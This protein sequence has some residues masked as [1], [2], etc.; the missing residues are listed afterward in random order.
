MTSPQNVNNINKYDHF[1]IFAQDELIHWLN[2]SKFNH[3]KFIK[4]TKCVIILKL[5]TDYELHFNY[6]KN[7]FSVELFGNVTPLDIDL[8][9]MIN[10]IIFN[11][12]MNLSNTL[13]FIV[14]TLLGI[15][16]IKYEFIDDTCYSMRINRVPIMKDMLNMINMVNTVNMINMVKFDELFGDVEDVEIDNNSD[17]S[18]NSNDSNDIK[19]IILETETNNVFNMSNKI[20]IDLDDYVNDEL[21]DFEQINK[22]DT[23]LDNLNNQKKIVDNINILNTLNTLNTDDVFKIYDNTQLKIIPNH[24]NHDN[25]DNNINKAKPIT[26]NV[27]NNINLIK[28]TDD[29]ILDLEAYNYVQTKI[30]DNET[31]RRKQLYY[32]FYVSIISGMRMIYSNL[33]E[34]EI[35]KI[36]KKLHLRYKKIRGQTIPKC[37]EELTKYINSE[38][39]KMLNHDID[40]FDESDKLDNMILLTD[41]K[42]YPKELNK[43]IIDEIPFLMNKYINIII[44]N[45][46]HSDNKDIINLTIKPTFFD[47]HS[48]I[49]KKLLNDNQIIKIKITKCVDNLRLIIIYPRIL[50][51][52]FNN[53]IHLDLK[54]IILTIKKKFEDED[55][56]N[57]MIFEYRKLLKLEI[58]I[59]EF[60]YLTGL[61]SEKNNKNKNNV[62]STNNGIGYSNNNSTNWNLNKF[63]SDKNDMLNKMIKCILD[64]NTTII[65]MID[66]KQQKIIFKILNENKML[67]DYVKSFFK[68]NKLMD[69]FKSAKLF[70]NLF[71]FVHLININFFNDTIKE[72]ITSL[73]NLI[74]PCKSYIKTVTSNT[75]TTTNTTTEYAI[76][77]QIISFCEFYEI[78]KENEGK[79]IED[80]INIDDISKLY[81]QE[82]IQYQFQT[83][84]DQNIKKIIHNANNSTIHNIAQENITLMNSMPLDIKSAIFYLCYE[85]DIY[86]NQFL[87]TGPEDTPYSSGCFLFSLTYP[88]NYPNSPPIVYFET[89]GSGMVQFNPNLFS[90]GNICLSLLKNHADREGEQWLPG[91]SSILQVMISLQSLVMVP[92]PFFNEISNEYI[93]NT[94]KG[95]IA[96]KEYNQSIQYY[97]LKYA[98]NDMIMNPPKHFET[99]IKKHFFIKKDI[100]MSIYKKYLN[101]FPD[102]LSYGIKKSQFESEYDIMIE[103]LNE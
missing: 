83:V 37:I 61:T 81:I 48:S 41:T 66:N 39:Y 82:L 78:Q 74:E 25:Y 47:S 30:L 89:T 92:K 100:I 45:F 6:S 77:N 96:S 55:A 73:I 26:S 90:N 10:C 54:N 2:K 43:K 32:Q 56:F 22:N 76:C 88:D 70:N 16:M 58:Q 60:E 75:K 1:D 63:I 36:I 7:Y 94:N 28:L 20:N 103:L 95:Q 71:D 17:N 11:N 84:D 27:T 29:L 102:K 38:K 68:N 98:I 44:F 67:L 35:E 69:I 51:Y 85:N 18:N 8:I 23:D 50:N 101:E 65:E 52:Q 99:I 72:I 24:D 86:Q 9:D 91:I 80:V 42:F 49:H 53:P 5:G 31:S 87:I 12:K 21:P 3:V 15:R 33:S 97:T 62:V 19:N 93:I 34:S 79:V 59:A 57:N 40:K 46:D 14:N 4:F 13:T 64:I